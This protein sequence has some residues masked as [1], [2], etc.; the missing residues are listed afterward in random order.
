MFKVLSPTSY[1]TLGPKLN[2]EERLQRGLGARLDELGPDGDRLRLPRRLAMR[3][4]LLVAVRGLET[5]S[6]QKVP[7]MESGLP[8]FPLHNIPKRKKI[9]QA[10]TKY[11]T[12][13][14]TTNN[15][16]ISRI[17]HMY[18]PTFLV[19]L[20]TLF[21]KGVKFRTIWSHSLWV[22]T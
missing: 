21:P 1:I 10:V 19:R 9:H 3:A 7:E 17:K 15:Y 6:V 22:F 4:G 5:K 2:L 14:D 8:D 11:T 18:I 13:M 16:E 12:K 20:N